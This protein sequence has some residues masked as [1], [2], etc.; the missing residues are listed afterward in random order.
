MVAT[1]GALG[2]EVDELTARDT[3]SEVLVEAPTV[4][5]IVTPAVEIDHGVPAGVA[6]VDDEAG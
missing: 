5:R 2:A 1:V 3:E 4:V 6:V